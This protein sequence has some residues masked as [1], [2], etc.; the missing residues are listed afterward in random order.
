MII[1]TRWL[2]SYVNRDQTILLIPPGKPLPNPDKFNSIR[3][4]E[5]HNRRV[6]EVVPSDRLLVYDVR[7]GWEPLCQFLDVDKC[8]EMPFPKTNTSF[9]VRIATVSSVLIPLILILFLLFK[10]FSFGLKKFSSKHMK[11]SS[12]RRWK[13]M[14]YFMTTSSRILSQKL[15]GKNW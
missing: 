11:P 3:S 10:V 5:E 4:Y 7:D 13:G 15:K 8:P 14:G 1:C 12:S 9:N 6:R 2:L